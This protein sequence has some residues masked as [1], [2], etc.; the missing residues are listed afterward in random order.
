MMLIEHPCSRARTF[1]RTVAI[2]FCDP[3][4]EHEV[5]SPEA[6]QAHLDARIAV[7]PQPAWPWSDLL[8]RAPPILS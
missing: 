6:T 5:I 2:A 8:D 1:S 3:L 4:T 7:D